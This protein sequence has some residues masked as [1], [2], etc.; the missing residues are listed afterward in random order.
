MEERGSQTIATV[1]R[2]IDVLMLF[3]KTKQATLGVTEIASE[4]VMSKAAVHRIL[5]SLKAKGLLEVHDESRRYALGPANLALGLAYLERIDIREVAGPEL[6]RLCEVTG[7]TAT[8]SIRSGPTRTYVSQV[9]PDREVKMTVPLGRPYPLHTGSS[10]K[11][12]LA[13]L[14]E[15][16]AEQ[17]LAGPL[18]KLTDNTIVDVVKLRAELKKIRKAGYAISF[19]ERQAGAASVAAPVFDHQSR[20]SAVISVCG[21]IERFRGEADDA[22]KLLLEATGRLSAR[23]GGR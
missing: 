8:L 9:T 13:F 3:T 14:G 23:F 5:S 1:E 11:A 6:A 2:A 10:S 17:Y 16:E 15:E 21:P 22:A 7:E 4:L 20:P 19:A 18:E 12:F